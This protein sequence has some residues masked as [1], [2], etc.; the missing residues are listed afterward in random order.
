MKHHRPLIYE[1]PHKAIRNA[2]SQLSLM[3]GNTDYNDHSEV[4][5]LKD[6]AG[7]V[8]RMLET[9]AH[10]ENNVPLKYLDQ[11]VPG[12][13]L[14]DRDDHNRIDSDLH[15]IEK[16]LKELI[17]KSGRGEDLTYAGNDFYIKLSSFHSDYLQHMLEEELE[18]Q[19]LMW[20]NF[21]DEELFM[22]EAE[23]RSSI[24][25]QEMLLWTKFMMPAFNHIKRIE[26]LRSVRDAAPPEFFKAMMGITSSVLP[27]E[28][29]LKLNRDL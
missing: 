12:S 28:A 6:L 22:Q 9:H 26:I 19:K 24:P 1:V 21:T 5:Q 16:T 17:S 18:T 27:A 23:I 15:K 10:H 14:H 13:S 20:D 8:F 25:P 3:A 4:E 2:L 29:F 7:Q 11:K